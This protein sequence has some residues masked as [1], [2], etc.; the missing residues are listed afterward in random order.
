MDTTGFVIGIV[1]GAVVGIVV[2][3]LIKDFI[4]GKL[5]DITRDG[6]GMI[7]KVSERYV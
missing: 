2:G 3:L 4:G 7:I 5:T 1:V 6:S